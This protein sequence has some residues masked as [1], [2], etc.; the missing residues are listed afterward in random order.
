MLVE[1]GLVEQRHK[2][3]LEVLEGG[4][5][6]VEVAGRFGVARQTVH[7]WL[8]DYA[9]EGIVGLADKSSKPATCPHQMAP[10]VE[11]RVVS[12]RREHPAWGPQTILYEL[13]REGAEP[14]P[15]RSSVYRALIRHGLIDPKQRRRRRSDTSG[16][17]GPGPWRCGR[18]TSPA[19]HL[20]DGS[21][22]S[23]VTGVDDNSR[24]CVYAKVVVRATAKPV[25][26][27]SAEGGHGGVPRYPHRRYQRQRQLRRDAPPGRE[28]VPGPVGGRGDR[29]QVGADLHRR[30]DRENPSGPSRPLEG[31]GPSPTP[32]ADPANPRVSPRRRNYL[33]P[34]YRNPSAVRV[35]ELDTRRQ[36]SG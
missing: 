1:L 9:R 18:R 36:S 30:Q 7:D 23:I 21:Q 13:A 29:G 6:V 27:A 5:S 31:N 26:D 32:R 10:E 17:N 25:C 15:G 20:A 34:R 3:V 16:G 33:S 24:F 14:L 2:A 8:R 28:P 11:A 22:A 19:V 4:L 12:L 35:P